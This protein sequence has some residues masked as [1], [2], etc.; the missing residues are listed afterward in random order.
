M[1]KDV[2][3]PPQE[4]SNQKR[5]IQ[6]LAL[7]LKRK[8]ETLKPERKLLGNYVKCPLVMHWI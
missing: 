4:N 1:Q 3:I 7:G 8:K 2:R 5:V 6:F